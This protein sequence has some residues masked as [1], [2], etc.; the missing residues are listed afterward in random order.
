MVVSGRRATNA[1]TPETDRAVGVLGQRPACLHHREGKVGHILGGVLLPI[2]RH[3]NG[4][5]GVTD[6]L[7]LLN[8]ML[9][10]ER[11]EGQNTVLSTSTRCLGA[12]RSVSDVKSTMS[13]NITVASPK[14]SASER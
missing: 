6:R 13:Q 3:S 7:D 11:V 12:I 4:H 9:G 8:S 2:G 1:I 5:V 14:T 10:G